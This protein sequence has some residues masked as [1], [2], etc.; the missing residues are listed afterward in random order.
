MKFL[1][2]TY[3][4]IVTMLFLPKQLLAEDLKG[5]VVFVGKHDETTPAVGI[6]IVINETGD[7]GR[8]KAGGL[9][10][11]SLP[12]RLK[13]RGSVTLSVSK[14]GW[15][16]QYPLDGETPIPTN[17]DTLIHVRLVPKGSK[18]LWSADRIEKFI[19]DTVEMAKDEVRTV[20]KPQEVDF[21]RYIR[22]WAMQ[23]GFSAQQAKNEIDKWV[24]ETEQD[25]DPHQLGLAAYARNNFVEAGKL[26]SESAAAK[27]RLSQEVSTTAKQLTEEAIRDYRL[28]GNA[29][30]DN[31]QFDQAI[32]AYESARQ[33]ISPSDEPI[34][35]VDL[36]VLIGNAETQ[37]GIRTKGNAIHQYLGNALKRYH[38]ALAVF[39]RE[40]YP[41]EWAR[42]QNSLGLVL[43]YQGTRTDNKAGTLLLTQASEAYRA[44]LTVFTKDASP[45]EWAM[46]QLNVGLVLWNQG[47][48][49]DGK[50]GTN[51]LAQAVATYREVLKVFTNE[52]FPQ[53]W[54]LT[55]NNLGLVLWEQSLRSGGEGGNRLLTEAVEA[56]RAALT[57]VTPD[58]FPEQWAMTQTN[59]ATTLVDQARRS[60]GTLSKRLLCEAMEAYQAV[61]TVHR[62]ES[63]P[64][65]WA[66]TQMN[67]GNVLGEQGRR[68]EGV[69]GTQLLV[70]SVAAYREALT[71]FTKDTLPQDWARTEL[72]LGTVLWS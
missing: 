15:V 67:L 68:E 9:F 17:L 65:A 37:I 31:Y 52:A 14:P 6:D 41:Q 33:L 49:T 60:E 58:S 11:I 8:T 69:Q 2:F 34:L 66:M 62:K 29:H 21:S 25:S 22:E 47:I 51:L 45:H 3:L 32:G 61:L 36:T 16:I 28:A 71:I 20:G 54:A 4:T 72:N 35:G 12:Q 27:I 19:R 64:Q 42:A 63:H 40:A 48:R 59:L 18:K 39:T 53:E 70:E 23:Y 57:V 13:A 56:L 43:L 7:S 26:F 24:T 1:I 10:R 30:E 5:K 38:E 50:T 46:I 55:Q 44:A